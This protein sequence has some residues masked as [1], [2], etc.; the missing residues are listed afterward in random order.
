VNRAKELRKLACDSLITL[1]EVREISLGYLYDKGYYAQHI[2]EQ[3][4]KVT[5]F[6]SK[7]IE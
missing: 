6:F 1:K 7:K 3:M 5:K 4:D 2:S